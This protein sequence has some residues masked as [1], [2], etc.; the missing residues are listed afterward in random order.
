[1]N[2]T[3]NTKKTLVAGIILGLV[4]GWLLHSTM[5]S[6]QPFISEVNNT[7]PAEI[8]LDQFWSV[9]NTIQERYYDIEFVDE[10]ELVWGAIEGLVGALDDRHSTFLNPDL[11][12]EFNINLTGELV[13]IGAELTVLDGRLT[14]STPI[15]G[16]PAEIAGLLPNDHIFLI[17]GEPSSE[18]SL[19]EAVLNIRGEKG[20][21]VTLTIL[22]EEADEPLEITITRD[23]INVPSV[24]LT[25]VE[26]EG[27]TIA[28]LALYR[29]SDDTDKELASAVREILLEDADAMILD[30]RLNGGGYLNTSVEVLNHFFEDQVVA[31]TVRSRGAEDEIHYTSG[32]GQLTDLPLVVLIDEGSASSSEIVTGALQDHERAIIMGEDSFGKGTVQVVN[33]LVDGS[34]LKLTIAKWFTPDDRNVDGVGIVPDI[35]VEMDIRAVD[36]SEDIQLNTALDYLTEL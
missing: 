21:E 28:N 23:D 36:S 8:D 29:F 31:L 20:T 9:W 19:H 3:Q 33:E 14:I 1:M 2:R 12:E 25:F 18:M 15:K 27:K 34:S 26:S 5:N 16:A 4:S 6:D 17:D 7:T 30:L 11:A 13:G 35:V 22:R 10:E 24:E 32:G